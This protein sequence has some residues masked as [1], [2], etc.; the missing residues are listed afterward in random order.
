MT[1]TDIYSVFLGTNDWWSGLSLGTIND[2]INNNGIGTTYGAY[3][4]II[5]KIRD[6]NPRARIILI[7]PMQR[8]DFVSTFDNFNTAYGSYRTKN[9]QELAQFADAVKEIGSL[10]H[11]QVVTFTTKA[12]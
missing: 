11:F 12:G 6:L 7:T 8:G 2:Y 1:K 10:E 4:V 5:N 9:G 3:R